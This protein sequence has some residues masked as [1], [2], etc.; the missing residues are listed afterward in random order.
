MLLISK[1]YACLTY[2]GESQ[3]KAVHLQGQILM[4]AGTPDS[5]LYT[6]GYRSV[7]NGYW[8]EA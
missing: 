7:Y 6:A 5:D 2:P 4:G 1:Q 3:V 8:R